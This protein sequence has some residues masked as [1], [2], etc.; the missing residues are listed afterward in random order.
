[1]TKP[2]YR[3]WVFVADTHGD[4]IDHAAY[5]A[6]R[7]FVKLFKPDL[8]IHGGDFVD[9]RALRQGATEDERAEGVKADVL[10]GID[11]L[12]WYRPHALLLGNHDHRLWRVAQY[13]R[14]HTKREYAAQLIDLIETELPRTQF[15]PYGKRNVYRMGHLKMIHGYHSGLTAAKRAAEVYGSVL[16]GHVH[17]IDHYS[18]PSIEPRMGWAVGC[19]CKLDLD[20]NASQPNTLRQAHGWAYGLLYP[21]GTYHPEQAK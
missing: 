4:M 5:A 13:A 14:D 20:Y 1:M 2:R 11:F 18:I 7:E 21:D 9:L 15:I 6:F 12:K 8:R 17:A 3:K 10:E 19:L 16:M